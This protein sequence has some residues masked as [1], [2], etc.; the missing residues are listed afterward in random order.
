VQLQPEVGDDA[1]DNDEDLQEL[2]GLLG[3]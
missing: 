3:V 1:G 2:L